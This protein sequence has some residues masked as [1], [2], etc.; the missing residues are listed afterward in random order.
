MEA[1]AEYI[2]CS[3]Q[4]Y[5]GYESGKTKLIHPAFYKIIEFLKI[6]PCDLFRDGYAERK[7]QI[8]TV[9]ES[10]HFYSEKLKELEKKNTDLI[11]EN[12]VLAYKL[13]LAE[14]KDL[15]NSKKSKKA[16]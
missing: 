6:D 10:I 2:G 15:E 12:A 1:V 9:S 11:A 4:S 13:Q 16:G 5:Q 14:D 8:D 7:E 3:Y